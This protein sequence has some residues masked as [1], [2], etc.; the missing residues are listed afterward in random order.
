MSRFAPANQPGLEHVAI[1]LLEG[2]NFSS[3]AHALLIATGQT[4]NTGMKWTNE[5]KN[6]VSD[7]WGS[8][9]VRTECVPFEI[10]LPVQ[11][12]RVEVFALDTKGNPAKKCEVHEKE[13]KAL[14]QSVGDTETMWYEIRL[15][16]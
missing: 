8:S 6:S 3:P 9:P 16:Q 10:T 7:Q 13:G 1:T 11:A 5:K 15:K 4:E 12:S 2:E 14:I